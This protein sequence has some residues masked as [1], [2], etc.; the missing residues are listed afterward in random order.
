MESSQVSAIGAG[1]GAGDDPPSLPQALNNALVAQVSSNKTVVGRNAAGAV[2]QWVGVFIVVSWLTACLDGGWWVGASVHT[3][4]HGID[5][6][7]SVLSKKSDP[8]C[9]LPNQGKTCGISLFWA[10]DRRRVI[11][12]PTMHSVQDTA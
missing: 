12:L 4:A 11:P 10:R 5:G 2:S 6:C 7:N 8:C 1:A 9:N 3:L